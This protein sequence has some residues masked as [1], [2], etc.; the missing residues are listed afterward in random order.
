[1]TTVKQ[2]L[3]IKGFNVWS[4]SPDAKIFDA[5][6]L[7]A[8]KQ[9]G[10]LLVMEGENVVGI[11]SERDYARKVALAGKSSKETPVREIM[12]SKLIVVTQDENVEECMTIMT[13]KRIR[14]L[15]VMD[16]NK[17]LGLVSIGDV[18]K[19]II[20]EQDLLISHLTNYIT[21]K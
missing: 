7:M 11:I 12:T 17:L 8:E 16:N 9:V 15:P 20:S 6:K 14:H 3:H 18:V 13:N 21:G 1:M 10:A 5:L 2:I 4:I 19:S